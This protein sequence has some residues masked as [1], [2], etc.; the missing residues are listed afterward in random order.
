MQCQLSFHTLCVQA[1]SPIANEFDEVN[2]ACLFQ[3]NVIIQMECTCNLHSWQTL[4]DG[5]KYTMEDT[6]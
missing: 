6:A 2:R 3:C 1:A 5:S 4:A